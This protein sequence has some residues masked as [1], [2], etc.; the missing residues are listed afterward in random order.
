MLTVAVTEFAGI[1]EGIVSVSVV[2]LE[3]EVKKMKS[4]LKWLVSY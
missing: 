4:L 2:D 3:V 1:E